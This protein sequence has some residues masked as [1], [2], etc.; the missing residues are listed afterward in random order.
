[1]LDATH[2]PHRFRL[3]NGRHCE[4]AT[5]TVD[6]MPITATVGFDCYRNPAEV[7]LNAGKCGSAIDGL[8]SDAAVA[9]SVALQCGVRASMLAK[10]VGRL[11]Q[12]GSAVSAIGAALDLV[13]SFEQR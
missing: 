3:P 11:D 9:I 5:L 13:A 8:L 2:G 12:T 10:S 6:G 1:M 7:F 4:T